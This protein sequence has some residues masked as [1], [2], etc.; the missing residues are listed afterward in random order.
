L[1]RD[2]AEET[3]ETCLT[4]NLPMFTPALN[5]VAG[6]VP[7]ARSR[8]W[9]VYHNEASSHSKGLRLT[10][11]ARMTPG[12]ALTSGGTLRAIATAALS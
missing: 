11:H 6:V 9:D 10:D 2:D 12:V 1:R 4:D 8:L 7:I 5:I 3:T